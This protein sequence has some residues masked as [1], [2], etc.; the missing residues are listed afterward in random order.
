MPHWKN[1]PRTN[2]NHEFGLIALC[3]T[4]DWC[5]V[6]TRKRTLTDLGGNALGVTGN[7]ADVGFIQEQIWLNEIKKG[8][9]RGEF[10]KTFADNGDEGFYANQNGVFKI[11]GAGNSTQ[12]VEIG[13]GYFYQ[14][15]KSFCS[16]VNRSD[17]IL[18]SRNLYG[19]YDTKNEEYWLRFK[20]DTQ[21]FIAG[22][23][24]LAPTTI[25]M[26]DEIDGVR[27]PHAVV[28]KSSPGGSIN[29][30]P[31][32]NIDIDVV[33]KFIDSTGSGVPVYANGTNIFAAQNGEWWRVKYNSLSGTFSFR[34]IEKD[35]N[36]LRYLS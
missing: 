2:E 25:T 21:Q 29:L 32:A 6:L 16:R 33:Y 31:I 3:R 1:H 26:F 12:I 36:E 4:N 14:I 27:I 7:G 24:P 23:T 5:E 15:Y 30:I 10:W 18:L 35:L 34:K 28:S 9:L 22:G 13:D 19:V 20:T 11:T 17:I 8:A